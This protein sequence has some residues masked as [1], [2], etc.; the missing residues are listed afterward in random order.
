[1]GVSS[2][3]EGANSS[4]EDYDEEDTANQ[5][6]G[7]L[8]GVCI[9]IVPSGSVGVIQRCG[10]FVGYQE[11]GCMLYC[12]IIHSITPKSLA[13][14]QLDCSSECKTKD[15]V[16]MT[17]RTA[18]VYRID[19]AKLKAAVFDIVDPHAQ[20]KA[21]VDDVVRSTL[22]TLLLDDAYLAKEEICH[23]ILSS[24][25][26]GMARYGH[27][28]MNVLVTDLVPEPKI[29]A[30]MNT[31]NVSRRQ[32]EA[33]LEEGE[34]QRILQVKAAEADA[35]A[36]YLSGQGMAKMRKAMAQGTKESMDSMSSGG[37]T[38]EDAMHMMITTQYLDTLKDFASN[39]MSSSVM[40]PK[41]GDALKDMETQVRDGLLAAHQAQA[42]RQQPMIMQ[43]PQQ[44]AVPQQLVA[45]R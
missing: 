3:E 34:A 23:R 37:L 45:G 8:C 16:T 11:P 38:K 2:G 26:S 36:K 31:I 24:V 7:S 32:R 21:A 1:M 22:P 35:E 39:P 14:K 18:V 6:V 41:K 19:K 27:K 28:I 15:N 43:Y 9:S 13:V 25:R 5:P 12:P 17:V 20:I 10:E 40:L 42:P 33:A 30:A 4:G 29:V 44:L